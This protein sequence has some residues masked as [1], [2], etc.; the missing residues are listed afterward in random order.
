MDLR[1]DDGCAGDCR[2]FLWFLGDH[3]EVELDCGDSAK[4]VDAGGGG[5]AG[6]GPLCD[7]SRKSNP[8][9]FI[10]SCEVQDF[11]VQTGPKA[12][13]IGLGTNTTLKT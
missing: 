10:A 11:V 9:W 8:C 13:E 2:I 12:T 3:V 5:G 7:V 4:K 1:G 6:T